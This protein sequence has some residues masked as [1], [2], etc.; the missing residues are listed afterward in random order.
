MTITQTENPMETTI[1]PRPLYQQVKDYILE[2]IHSGEWTP[3]MKIASENNLVETLSVSRMTVNRALRELAAEEKLVRLQGVGTFV[4]RRKPR[5]EFLEIRSIAREIRDRGGEHTCDVHLLKREKISAETASQMGL[6]TRAT[7]FHAIM[8]HKENSRP[9]QLADR[10]INPA[11]AP[12]FLEQDFSRITP[13]EYLIS[14]APPTEVEHVIEAVMPDQ[15]TMDLLQI[16]D[17]EPCLVLH[18]RT[19]INGQ[20]ATQN[21]FIHP[22]SRHTMGS[23]F[24]PA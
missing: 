13:N 18:R 11:V 3:D 16:P 17:T 8:V 7:V 19:W 14:L 1:T 24:K 15:W 22:G 10:Y 21:R 6:D 12:D 9:V 23:R 5:S 2:K 20:V 4:A